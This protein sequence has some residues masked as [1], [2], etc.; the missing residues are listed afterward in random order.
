LLVPPKQ[1]DLITTQT[2]KAKTY[3]TDDQL[4]MLWKKSYIHENKFTELNEYPKQAFDGG[5]FVI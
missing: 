1:Q 3:V 5:T 4:A 2:E